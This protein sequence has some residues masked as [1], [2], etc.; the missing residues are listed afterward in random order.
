MHS[1]K[2]RLPTLHREPQK[3]E[4]TLPVLK[5]NKKP[6]EIIDLPTPPR[7]SVGFVYRQLLH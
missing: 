6:N 7:V 4:A 1:Q 2:S 3:W 5:V